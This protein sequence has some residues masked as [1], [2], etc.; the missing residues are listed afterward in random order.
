MLMLIGFCV[1]I[2]RYTFFSDTTEGMTEHVE[3]WEFPWFLS[4][5][6]SGAHSLIDSFE[7]KHG[8]GNEGLCDDGLEHG[9]MVFGCGEGMLSMWLESEIYVDDTENAH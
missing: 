6:P 7:I 3:F 4:F 1:V 5:W 2:C 8:R 9:K